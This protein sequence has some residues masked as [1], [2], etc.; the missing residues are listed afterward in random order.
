MSISAG[1][2][3]GQIREFVHEYQLQPHGRKGA[4]LAASGVTEARLRR[5]QA[6]VYG[7]DL[8]LGQIPRQGGV[9]AVPPGR[10]NALE[11]ARARERA[12]HEAEVAR[13]NARI[14]ELEGANDSLGKAIGLLH[15]MSEHEPAGTP[16]TTGP[17]DSSTPRT[18]SSRS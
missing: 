3:A 11:K 5:W 9:V 10:R 13:L 7:G 16:E 6:A 17:S 8:D 12:E 14:R 1:F 18:P 4:W 15:A 2:T